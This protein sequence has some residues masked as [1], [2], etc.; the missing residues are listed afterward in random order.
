[1][2]A[3]QEHLGDE[4]IVAGVYLV[5]IENG[6]GYRRYPLPFRGNGAP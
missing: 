1:M 3:E 5:R 2:L 6:E 4:Q